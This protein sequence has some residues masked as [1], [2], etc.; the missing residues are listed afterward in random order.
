M[1]LRLLLR[2]TPVAAL[3]VFA[4]LHA[5]SPNQSEGPA[6]Q[7]QV[8]EG[9]TLYY[10]GA[11]RKALAA[12]QK[13][14]RIDAGN[15]EAWL[16]GAVLWNELDAPKN[17]AEWYRQA[18]L[19][20]PQDNALRIALGETEMRLGNFAEARGRFIQAV[21][22]D[23]HDPWAL[24][25]LGRLELIAGEPR[26]ALAPLARAA[27]QDPN[28]TLAHYFLGKAREES[29]DD[30][31]AIEAYQT[32]SL[33]DSYFTSA[34]YALTQSFVRLKR[35]H[36][37][38]AQLK[39]LSTSAPLN[40]HIKRL[41]KTVQPRLRDVPR[42]API[43]TVRAT[44]RG[45]HPYIAPPKGQVPMLRIGVGTTGMGRPLGWK[46][47]R[48][49]CRGAFELIGQ[50]SGKVYG[51][52]RSG[53]KWTVRIDAQG[54]TVVRDHNNQRLL[55][56]RL[57]FLIRP[58]LKRGGWTYLKEMGRNRELG[59]TLRGTL[60]VSNMTATRKLKI[61]NIVN[62]ESYTQGVL[63]AEMPIASPIEALKAQGVIARTHALFMKKYRRRHRRDGYD[64]CDGQ[65]C[66]V[67]YGVG[68]ETERARKIIRETR[69]RVITHEGRA[70]DVLYSSNC[71][72]HTQSAGDIQ[73]WNNVPYFTGIRDTPSD[74]HTP[75]SPWTLRQWL[76]NKPKAHCAPSDYVYPAHYRWSRVVAAKDLEARINRSYR[77]GRLKSITALKRSPSGH[78]NEI[79]IEGTRKNRKI[80]SEMSIRGLFGVGSQRSTLF[81]FDT[82]IGRD[83]YP[84]RFIF[85]GGGWGHGVGMCQSGAM[86]RAERGQS[87]T[88][89][90]QAYFRGVEIGHLRY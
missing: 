35:F 42:P 89:I 22:R 16:N 11:P 18:I 38:W 41:K 73:G 20:R 88:K 55:R 57:P 17:A 10:G 52:G 53:Q 39:K 71:G 83:G 34:R 9:H 48:F 29:G 15:A 90:L 67:Y 24:T 77:I 44:P 76:R 75:H 69:G 59:R 60:E 4:N 2:A 27:R 80:T 37:A 26:A 82:E 70:A 13:A 84:N 49:T 45:P 30:L 40:R 23:P 28:F 64:L 63:T 5:L 6:A 8:L 3:V 61:V 81:V 46:N 14:L 62:L 74:V 87:Y 65:H 7:T 31:G 85:Y 43:K 19:L 1:M 51:R 33:T 58:D 32:A 79:L 12:Y 72:G 66:Q 86:G 36:E 54:Y 56:T 47:F 50:R 78:I 21:Q 25:S 68:S